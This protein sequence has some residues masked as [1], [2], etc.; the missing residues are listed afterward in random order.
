[1]TESLTRWK[2][3]I[4][5]IRYLENP[6]VYSPGINVVEIR[7]E[8]LETETKYLL[9]FTEVLGYRFE[10]NFNTV[11]WGNI[12]KVKESTWIKA[13]EKKPYRT[14]NMESIQHYLIAI[15]SGEFQV[16]CLEEPVVDRIV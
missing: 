12:F 14:Q 16:V 7:L 2:C 13:I 15:R 5:N 3:P 11:A 9:K 4:H 10:S 1:M 8:D 6:V